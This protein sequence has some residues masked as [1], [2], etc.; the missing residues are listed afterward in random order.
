MRLL[1][2]QQGQGQA[3]S[4][5]TG[6]RSEQRKKKKERERKGGKTKRKPGLYFVFIESGT[7]GSFLSGASM[8]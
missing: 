3:E 6:K 8:A 1:R 2:K 4:R 7:I 5:L